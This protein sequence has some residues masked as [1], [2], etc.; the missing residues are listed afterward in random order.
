[1]GELRMSHHLVVSLESPKVAEAF[2]NVKVLE[3]WEVVRRTRVPDTAA[4]LAKEFRVTLKEAQAMLDLPVEAGLLT[5]VRA[6]ARRPQ[7]TCVFPAHELV[8]KI[9]LLQREL[10]RQLLDEHDGST[11]PSPTRRTGVS[12]FDSAMLGAKDLR[13]SMKALDVIDDVVDAAHERAE[14]RARRGVPHPLLGAETGP[15]ERKGESDSVWHDHIA[16]ELRPLLRA[17]T[18]TPAFSLWNTEV[19]HEV[20][21]RRE[22]HP[23]TILS[24][25]ELEIAKRLARGELRPSIAKSPSLSPTPSRRPRSGSTRSSG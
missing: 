23:T 21:T 19:A 9:R 14:E 25:R 8:A 10:S 13:R 18:P 1:M 16:F 4:K 6:S 15:V 24:E 17:V 22:R 5:R 20:A 12:H 7:I 11:A 3:R 2:L